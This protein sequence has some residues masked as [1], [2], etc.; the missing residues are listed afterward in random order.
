MV[1]VS[2]SEDNSEKKKSSVAS[3]FRVTLYSSIPLSWLTALYMPKCCLEE[4]FKIPP[5]VSGD[6]NKISGLMWT[7]WI[8]RVWDLKGKNGRKPVAVCG[9]CRAGH[10][11]VG[12]FVAWRL[13][14]VWRRSSADGWLVLPTVLALCVVRCCVE[15]RP[16]NEVVLSVLLEGRCVYEDYGLWPWTSLI[17]QTSVTRVHVMSWLLWDFSVLESREHRN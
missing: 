4:L 5:A 7:D 12:A 1:L 14:D 9:I 15:M 6:V 8:F 16:C 3:P 2:A 13:G 11:R 10:P 17:W